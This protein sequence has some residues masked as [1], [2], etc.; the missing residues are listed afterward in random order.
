MS[1]FGKAKQLNE[2]RKMSSQAK[3]LQ[4]ELADI[5]ETVEKD[6]ILVKVS[7]DQKVLYIKVDGEERKDIVEAVNQAFKDIQKKAAQKMIETGGLSS[8]LGG[9]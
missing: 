2:L 7:A 3:K 6:N 8:L 4:K 5:T 1:V 9:M